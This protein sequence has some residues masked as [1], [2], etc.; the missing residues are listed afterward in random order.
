MDKFVLCALFCGAFASGAF[1]APANPVLRTIDNDGDSLSIRT[2]GDEHYRFTQTE[3][4][5]LVMRDSSGVFFFADEEGGL[6]KFKAKNAGRRSAEEKAFLNGL[7]KQKVRGKHREKHPDKFR[8]PDSKQ[9]PMRAS[10]VPTAK[11][12]AAESPAPESAPAEDAPPVMRLPK[13]SSHANGTNRFP[14]FM[15][16]NYQAKNLDSAKTYA[17]MNQENY[18]ANGY[19]GSIRDYFVDQ[20]GG[21]FAPVF[22]L[23]FLTLNDDFSNYI[24][25]EDLFIQT[26]LSAFMAQYP[27]F[28]ATLYDADNDGDV[29]A[30][31]FLYAGEQVE[32][33]DKHLGGFQYELRWNSSGKLNA[34][35]G[36]RFNNYFILNQVG[37]IFE[38]FIHEFSHTM[39]LRDHY[40]VW[41]D[42]CYSDFTYS[43]V[44]APGTHAWDVMA[45]GM[46][47]GQNNPPNYSAFERNFM[48][49]LDYTTLKDDLEKKTLP[50]LGS[51]NYAYYVKVT[52]DEWYVFENRQKVKWD[53]ALPNHG[54][55]VWH[56]DYN[57]QVWEQDALNDVASH[58]RVDVVEAGKQ[59][60]TGYYDGF[61]GYG[62]KH[63]NDDPFP[64][65]D[66]VT[67]L[68]PLTAWNGDQLLSGLYNITE[69]D[70]AVCFSVAKDV[71]VENCGIVRSSSSVA[72]SSSS[73]ATSSSATS[74]AASSSSAFIWPW[75]SSSSVAESSSSATERIVSGIVPRM[76]FEA[77]YEGGILNVV[78]P[79][80]GSKTVRIFDLQGHQ[81]LSESFDGFSHGVNLRGSRS[82]G[83]S[84]SRLVVRVDAGGRSLGYGMVV[85][86]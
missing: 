57:R 8:R 76:E 46:Y 53:A 71:A 29:D 10:W 63:L 65:S 44:Q 1:A 78:A 40:C 42:N 73:S 6:S 48:G 39:G 72:E 56:I 15:V 28:D 24:G 3:D 4:G 37:D 33:G 62:S 14:V 69:K 52:S 55:L 2:I 7:D 31:A 18:R 79:V 23:Y 13:P 67:E 43:D 54:M 45:T 17:F 68:A 58:Q 74:S 27:D 86:R 82:S 77:R 47:N 85:V 83:M 66:K 61:A 26:A 19:V 22:D 75:R 9:K 59:R 36:K 11:S 32:S 38:R 49:W 80:Q 35:N 81:L 12:A 60:V 51:D 30:F 5:F 16:G 70:S 84:G 41:A 34:G 20:S 50:P 25:K 21:L 64:G